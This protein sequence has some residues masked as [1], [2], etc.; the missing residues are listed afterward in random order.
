MDKNEKKIF[1]QRLRLAAET[2]FGGVA[3][4][5]EIWGV[6]REGIYS[7]FRG[8]RMPGTMLLKLLYDAG[9][10]VNWLLTGEGEMS[11]QYD[12]PK[13]KSKTVQIPV[14]A[15]VQC[16]VP[17]AE[18]TSNADKHIEFDGIRNLLNPFGVIAQGM[19]MAQTILP[20]D[21]LICYEPIEDI[22]DHSIVL[23]SFKTEPETS[24][25]LIKRVQFNKDSTLTLYSDNS[26]NFPPMI[27]KESEIFRLY[28]VYTKFLRNLK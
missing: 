25:G 1:G 19:S 23:V 28:P 8:E 9:L 5:A 26:R 24:V 4:L 20:G 12:K 3:G 16:G 17:A 13:G 18:F 22:I 7:Y 10:N 21:V 15:N 6:M 11:L 27:C 2:M 14:V